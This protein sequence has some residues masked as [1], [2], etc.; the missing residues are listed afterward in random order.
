MDSE[1]VEKYNPGQ[2]LPVFIF[3]KNNKEVKR[4]I[5]E[6][7]EKEMLKIIEELEI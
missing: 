4:V 2:I 6:K 5:G 7:T 3:F 1:E